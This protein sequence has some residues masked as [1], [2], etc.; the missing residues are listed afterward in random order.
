MPASTLVSDG[1]TDQEK[2]GLFPTRLLDL[3]CLKPGEKLDFYQTEHNHKHNH[4]EPSVTLS[5]GL[6]L[7]YTQVHYIQVQKNYASY[8][9]S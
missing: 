3:P 2:A 5:F 8:I 1:Q 6:K 4:K 9:V 7:T